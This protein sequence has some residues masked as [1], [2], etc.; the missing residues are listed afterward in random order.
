ML[1]LANV[2]ESGAAFSA[3]LGVGGAILWDK[4][5]HCDASTHYA[6]INRCIYV[7]DIINHVHV[8]RTPPQNL[9]DLMTV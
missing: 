4:C 2:L 9:C 7:M 3:C 8:T 6:Y 5:I 1:H